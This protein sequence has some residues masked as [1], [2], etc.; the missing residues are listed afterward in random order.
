MGVSGLHFEYP[1]GLVTFSIFFREMGSIYYL[2]DMPEEMERDIDYVP[3]GG[4]NSQAGGVLVLDSAFF[5]QVSFQ[6]GK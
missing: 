2:I 3:C 6:S 1:A 5:E 4:V